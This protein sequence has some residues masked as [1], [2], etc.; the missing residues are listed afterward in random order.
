MAFL[1]RFIKQ[2]FIKGFKLLNLIR[3]LILNVLFLIIVL[4]IFVSFE[5]Q[6]EQIKVADNS[7]LRLNLNGFIV[8]KK[9]PVNISQE[10]SKQLTG[11]DQEI[12]QEFETQ[13][14][15]KTIR[16]AQ[17]DPKITGLVLE[18]SGLQSASLDQLTDIGEA[19][20]LFKTEG[21]PVFAYAD[22]YTQTQY[23]LAAY[24]DHIT[25]PPNGFVLLQGYSV[26]RLYFKDLLDKLLVTPHIFKVG[27]Y[28]SFVEPFTETEMSQYSKEANNI[29]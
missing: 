11:L 19:I 2:L 3:L 4:V 25:L 23:Y 13:E 5:T 22:N 17:H 8:E 16:N 27:T 9:H 20:N 7:Y 14:L 6:D 21:K 12:P 1:F 26:N 15:I 29:G 28:K 24:A 18:L 10:I